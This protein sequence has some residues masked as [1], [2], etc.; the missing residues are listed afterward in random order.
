MILK[1]K[2]FAMSYISTAQRMVAFIKTNTKTKQK[3]N[4]SK[5]KQNK[6]SKMETSKFE[7]FCKYVP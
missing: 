7:S 6:I 1:W 4:K 5:T 3:Q 2:Q